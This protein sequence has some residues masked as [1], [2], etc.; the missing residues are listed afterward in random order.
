MKRLVPAVALACLGVGLAPA[1]SSTPTGQVVVH[2]PDGRSAHTSRLPSAQV[3]STGILGLE[4]TLGFD[5]RGRAYVNGSTGLQ[6]GGHVPDARLTRVSANGGEL[7]DVSPGHPLTQDPYV[8]SDP[9]TGRVFDVDLIDPCAQISYTD[10][11]DEG[12]QHAVGG[13]SLSDH[14]TVFAGP[15]PKGGPRPSGYPNV[16]YYCA[17]TFG[18]L[19]NSSF[20]VGCERSLDGGD[21]WAPTQG[22]PFTYDPMACQQ[23]VYSEQS[24]CDGI[25][26]QGAVAPNGTVLVPKGFARQPWLALSDD[27]GRTW[28]RVRVAHNGI[29]EDF[30]GYGDGQ[31]SVAVD[32]A[33]TIYYGW[34]AFDRQPYVAWSRNNGRTWS[35][36][37]RMGRPG[38]HQAWHTTLDAVAPGKVAVYYLGT[39]NGPSKPF[40]DNRSCRSDDPAT[41][42]GYGIGTASCSDGAAAYEHTTWNGYLAVTS[43]LFAPD[44]TLVTAR[45]NPL[46]D[47]LTV[48]QCGALRCQQQYDFSD[49]HISPHDGT[50][51]AAYV[52]G[53]R[54]ERHCVSP[55]NGRLA[56]LVGIDLR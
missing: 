46:A 50:P 4:P 44:P 14:Q 24:S 21:T 11:A 52:D 18:A 17:I 12:W 45:L 27:E 34:T 55:G 6:A 2:H 15:A 7:R 8:Y 5:R 35:K 47:P 49:V 48:G 37:V 1:H 3:V 41:D 38:L 43:D 54:D 40:P 26:G 51:W 20:A 33:G 16:V 39:E 36:P 25:S 13:C 22:Q 19:A 42:L 28:R 53:C 32:R 9:A 10:N 30:V 29:R 56:R 23:G 31:T